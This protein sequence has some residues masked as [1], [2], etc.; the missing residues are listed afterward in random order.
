[1][2]VEHL[3]KGQRIQ[4]KARPTGEQTFLHAAFVT[5]TLVQDLVFFVNQLDLRGERHAVAAPNGEKHF[6]QL[7]LWAE[8]NAVVYLVGVL[9]LAVACAYLI[10]RSASQRDDR[11]ERLKGERDPMEEKIRWEDG[12][13]YDTCASA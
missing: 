6:S 8:I 4:K 12:R 1:M 5:A 3:E 11:E 10:W 13:N 7:P 9:W 2:P